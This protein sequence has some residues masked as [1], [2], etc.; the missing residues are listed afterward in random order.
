MKRKIQIEL[1]SAKN[2]TL[3]GLLT[4][5]VLVILKL[6]F[7]TLVGLKRS[8]WFFIHGSSKLTCSMSRKNVREGREW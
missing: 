3:H 2:V 5:L 6:L 8:M 7:T 1:A 4:S